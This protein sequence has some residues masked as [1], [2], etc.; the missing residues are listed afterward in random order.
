MRNSPFLRDA[1]AMD[2]GPPAASPRAP[3][4]PLPPG[5]GSGGFGG[6]PGAGALL[7]AVNSVGGGGPVPAFEDPPIW[8][9]IFRFL[10]NPR[11]PVI[12]AMSRP[13]AKKNITTLVRAYGENRAL[14]D[15]ANLVLVMGNRKVIDG[16]AASSAKVLESVLKMVDAYDLY[17]R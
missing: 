5:G 9:E 11:K 16:M 4:T 6:G 13:D 10:R 3:P 1:P 12:L 2:I 14:R 7:G 15:I 8:Q 17:G